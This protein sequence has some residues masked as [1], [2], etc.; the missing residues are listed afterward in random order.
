MNSRN[1]VLKEEIDRMYPSKSK[2]NFLCCSL[3]IGNIKVEVNTKGIRDV[4]EK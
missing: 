1:M 4:V 3:Y 2:S